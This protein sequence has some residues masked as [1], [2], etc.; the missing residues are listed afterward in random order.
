MMYRTVT[1]E[2]E[3][4]NSVIHANAELSD[5]IVSVTPEFYTAIKTYGGGV[6]FY[7]GP[8]DFT[9]T[10]EEQ[11]IQING[12]TAVGNITINPIPS[13][14]GLITWDGSVLTVS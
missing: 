6:E 13:N 4:V 10:Q 8:Y 2:A 7:D 14:Y 9:P 11:T 3:I 12:K 1:V 5:S